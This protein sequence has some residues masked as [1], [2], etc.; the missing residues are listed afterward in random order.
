MDPHLRNPSQTHLLG[1]GPCGSG[2]AG[3][4]CQ[5]PLGRDL[6]GPA[7][8]CPGTRNGVSVARFLIKTSSYHKFDSTTCLLPHYHLGTR[9]NVQAALFINSSL[10]RVASILLT[11]TTSYYKTSQ[12]KHYYLPILLAEDNLFFQ[13]HLPTIPIQQRL[14]NRNHGCPGRAQQED[15]CH[16]R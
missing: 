14:N 7:R 13:P 5:I 15:G 8:T 16:L 4:L 1:L 2:L 6:S 11:L 12:I 10:P 9:H 3:W